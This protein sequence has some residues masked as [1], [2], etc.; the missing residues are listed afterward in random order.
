MRKPAARRRLEDA[1]NRYRAMLARGGEQ[2]NVAR[3][4]VYLLDRF[5][6]MDGNPVVPVLCDAL[7]AGDHQAFDVAEALRNHDGIGLTWRS[8]RKATP[9]KHSTAVKRRPARRQRWTPA[10]ANFNA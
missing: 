7:A 1:M 8:R 6:G 10:D 3:I 4:C 5:A 2:A 9:V